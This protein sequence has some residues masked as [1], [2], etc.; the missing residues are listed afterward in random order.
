MD[1]PTPLLI[2]VAPNGARKSKLDHPALPI[3]P[4][5]LAY[6]AVACLDAGA[7]MLHLH[8]RDA[9]GRHSILAEHYAPAI[10]AIAAAVGDRLVLQVTSESAGIYDRHQQIQAIR[11]LMP[12]Q[13]S[14][15]LRELVPD[16]NAYDDAARLFADLDANGSLVQYILY[17]LNDVQHF[18]TLIAKGVIPRQRN[19]VLLVL[20]RY[21]QKPAALNEL[22]D[23]VPQHMGNMPWMCCAFGANELPIMAQVI[24]AGGHVRVGFENNTQFASGR[25]VQNNQALVASVAMEACM[26]GRELA[27]ATWVR[28]LQCELTGRL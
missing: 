3:T 17:D 21:G 16:V 13:V 7:A 12:E 11:S 8:V 24:T 28:R 19:L 10:D 22:A 15:G 5:E 6:T 18:H 20:G 9:E 1:N 14:I 25:T 26:Q 4:A 2:T 23:Y 27:D